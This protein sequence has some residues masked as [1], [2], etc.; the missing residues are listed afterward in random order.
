MPIIPGGGGGG[1]SEILKQTVNTQLL[2]LRT[3]NSESKPQISL[4]IDPYSELRTEAS[5]TTTMLITNNV[6][7]YNKEFL[8]NYSTSQFYV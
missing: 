3:Q 6:I 2:K 5:D 1:V 7:R 4:L 8:S